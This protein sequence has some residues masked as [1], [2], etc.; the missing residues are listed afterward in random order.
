MLNAA[1]LVNEIFKILQK[2]YAL[3]RGEVSTYFDKAE[4]SENNYIYC[5]HFRDTM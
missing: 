1:V 5:S 2:R 3:Y 4:S